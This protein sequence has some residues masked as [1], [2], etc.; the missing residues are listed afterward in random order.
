[1][2][3]KC[4]Q[5]LLGL[6]VLASLISSCQQPKEKDMLES[7]M[8]TTVLPSWEEGEVKK[9]II[10][11]V[12]QA[13]DTASNG[14][15]PPSERIAVF[16]ND[17]TLW[18][19]VPMLFQMNFTIDRI[20]GMAP[21][22]PEWNSQQPFKTILDNGYN[23]IH[24]L[25]LEDFEKLMA[26]THADI[27]SEAFK[28]AA[29][30]WFE[31]SKHPLYGL[32]YTQCVYQ[33]QL[34]LLSYLQKNGF[35]NYIVSGGG[36]DFIRAFAEKTYGIP[37]EQVIGSSGRTEVKLYDGKPVLEKTPKLQSFDDREEKIINIDL[38][39]GRRPVIACGNSD[40][41]LAMLQYTA[42]GPTSNLV[43]LIHHDDAVR[44][45]AYDKHPL[46]GQLKEGLIEAKSK[47]WIVVSMQKDWRRIFPETNLMDVT[48][49]NED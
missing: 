34:E 40:G 11:F 48:Q 37:P 7:A 41:D 45:Q 27:T 38:H 16:D 21:Q 25:R 12:K 39:I 31:S 5:L 4:Q 33:P 17:G 46:M 9:R 30:H 14:Y 18:N 49:R 44:E 6:G 3:K 26:A 43:I 29:K 24:Q 36:V 20:R 47:N 42:T 32:P 8:I 19:E 23:S 2:K 15:I 10:A 13:T 1:M 22:H 28:E 35:K